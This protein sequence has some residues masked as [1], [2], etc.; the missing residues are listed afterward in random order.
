MC[1]TNLLPEYLPSP[2]VADRRQ[3]SL[4]VPECQGRFPE[5]QDARKKLS[6]PFI[7]NGNWRHDN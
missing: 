5:R 1:I 3:V 2:D 7:K 6:L 4:I